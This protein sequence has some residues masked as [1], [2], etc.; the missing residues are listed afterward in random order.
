MP[1]GWMYE[2]EKYAIL[3][4][5]LLMAYAEFAQYFKHRKS[6]IKF[7]LG[8]M[9]LYWAVYYS[10]SIYRALFNVSLNLHQIFVRSGILLTL[11]LV[12]ANALMTLQILNRL[13]RR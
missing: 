3:V 10:Y 5:A 9:A 7:A 8:L 2:L 1:T 4:V 11:A 13:D 6:W 12:A